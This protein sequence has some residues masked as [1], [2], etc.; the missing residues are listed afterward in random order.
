MNTPH[1]HHDQPF[2]ITQALLHIM[3][4]LENAETAKVVDE[5]RSAWTDAQRPPFP[6]PTAFTA[7]DLALLVRHTALAIADP[8]TSVADR[9]DLL[10]HATSGLHVVTA[11]TDDV[12]WA[13]VAVGLDANDD[14]LAVV[15]RLLWV[16]DDLESIALELDESIDT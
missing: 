4:Q 14:P 12:M 1:E 9:R 6:S 10:L 13:A 16:L 7:R 5:L 3:R 15:A 2:T 11:S 8:E